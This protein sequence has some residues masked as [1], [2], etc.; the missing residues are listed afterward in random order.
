M[1][2]SKENSKVVMVIGA[3]GM[4]EIF[5]N[6]DTALNFIEDESEGH[7]PELIGETVLGDGL[8]FWMYR[9]G[10][11]EWNLEEKVVR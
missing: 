6:R 10:S 2:S 7:E 11:R 9:C 4:M 1:S 3:S 8:Q 5:K